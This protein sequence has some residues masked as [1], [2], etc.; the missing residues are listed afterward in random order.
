MDAGTG[1]PNYDYLGGMLLLALA[2]APSLAICI[3]IFYKESH[4]REPAI[5]LVMSFLWGMLTIVPAALIEWNLNPNIPRN[6]AGIL[7]ICFIG[8]ALVE[9]VCKYVV[10]RYYAF[11]RTSFDE[12]LDGIMYSVMVAMGFATVENIMYVTDHGFTVA[13]MRM[14]TSVPGHATF[15]V[16]MGYYAG[17]AKFDM[18][19]RKKLLFTGVAWATIAHGFYDSFLF[20]SENHWMKQYVSDFLLFAGAMISLFICIRFSRK[21]I[22]LHE[23]TSDR[24]YTSA[25]VLTI[26]NASFEDIELIRTLSLQIWPH[27][28]ASI[29]TQQQIHYMLDMIYSESALVKQIQ[30]NHQFIIVYNAGIPIGF[31]SYNEIEPSIYK[32]QKIYI[33]PQQQGRG[34]GRFVIGQVIND[35]RPKGAKALQLHVNRNNV[36]RGFYEKMGF[37]VVREVDTDIGDGFY[38]NDYLMQLS[39]L[40]VFPSVDEVVVNSGTGKNLNF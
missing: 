38:M 19:N 2:I 40:E 18:A 30:S 10:L 12:P 24:L 6:V 36:A 14:F 21:M 31:A 7:F 4:N 25:P 23:A 39:L 29:L 35:I 13:F 9:E 8:I 17:K 11:N 16:I 22:R 28:Y 33:L 26:R 5:N 1:L 37:E 15:G 34:A 20:L 32:L 3:Y 27:T